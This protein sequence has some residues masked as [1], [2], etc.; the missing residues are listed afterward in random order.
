MVIVLVGLLHAPFIFSDPDSLVSTRSRGAWTDEGLNTSQ[1]RNFVNHGYLSMDEC[2]NLI[3]TP[4]FGLAL[5]SSYSLLGTHIWVGRLL[6]LSSL[7]MIL[8]LFLRR[9]ET[10]FFGTTLTI[11]ALLQF[12]VFHFSHYSLAEIM[13][14]SWILAG[15]YLL[16]I[17]EQKK[18]WVWMVAAT[19]CF[20]FAFL[21]KIT[22]AYAIFIPFLVRFAQFISDS[23]NHTQPSRPLWK[24]WGIQ[25]LITA[26]FGATFYLKWYLPNK[27]VFEMVRANQGQG[28][29]DM[30]DAWNRFHF[31]LNEFILV[32]GILPF[33]L[34]VPIALF[35]LLRV[36]F[37][38]DKQTLFFGLLI[39]L[40]LELHHGL[41]INPPTRYLLPLYFAC[42]AIVA[43]ALSEFSTSV[44]KRKVV[45]VLL[46]ILGGFNLSHYAQSF[47]RRT[48]Q[49]QEVQE[50][51][52]QF[53]LKNETIIGVWGTT[54]AAESKARS[55]PI[56]HEF[57]PKYNPIDIYKPRIIFSEYN[58]NES[59]EAYIL[60]G[61]DLK[62]EA[63]SIKQFSLW[64]YDVNLYWMKPD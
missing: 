20:P 5:Y 60:R 59:G 36:K 35:V 38:N 47:S 41:L 25:T 19:A 6:V 26:F 39:W 16:W 37:T 3:K 9:C 32:D 13:A 17:S 52:S 56:W 8:F 42:L 28:R 31:N 29:Y 21:S 48:F 7:L 18:H 14:I 43:F 10:R 50:Y 1:V 30:G 61:I 40:V 2:D 57:N 63:D 58:E 34:L 44:F 64:R 51:L 49:I 27:W 4:L 11:I 53:N 22:F 23:I 24:D 55:I 45:W 46:I 62:A 12:H 33:I 54:L 15:I